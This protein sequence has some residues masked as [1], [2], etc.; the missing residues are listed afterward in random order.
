MCGIAGIYYFD[1][2]RVVRSDDLTAMTDRIVHRGPDDSGFHIDG[3]VGI[4]MRRLSIIDLAGGHQPMHTRDR[5]LSIVFNGEL[6]NFQDEKG[7]LERLGHQFSTRS[8]TEVVLQLFE[9]HGE[10]FTRHLNGMFGA[11]I[12]DAHSKELTLVRDHVGIKPLY[13]YR[14]RDVFLFASEIKA[15]LAFPGLRPEFDPG[16]LGAYLRHGFTPAP[17]TLFKGIRKLRPAETLRVGQNGVAEAVY[18]QPSYADKSRSSEDELKEELFSLIDD[19]V[20]RQ[21]IADVPI[22]AFLSG[23]FD[24]SGIVHLMSKAASAPISTYTVGFGEKY[25]THNE[26]SAAN[27]FSKDYGTHQHQIVVKP[28]VA[29]L[30]PGLVEALDEPIADSSFILT[31]LVAKL[32]RQSSTVIL[33]GVGGDELFGGYRRYLNVALSRPLKFVPAWVRKGMVMPLLRQLPADRNGRIPNLVRL[34]KSYLTSAD[35]PLEEQYGGY[36]QVLDRSLL[37]SLTTAQATTPDFYT[38][39]FQGCDSTELLDKMMYFDLK[40]SLPEQL[41]LLTDK[42]TMAVSLEARVP[43]LDYRIVEFAARLPARLKVNGFKLRYLQKE[44]FRGR[45]PDYVYAQPKKGFGAPVG[46][47]LRSEL[48]PLLND[49][50]NPSYLKAQG[51][52]APGPVGELIQRHKSR[53]EDHTDALWALIVFQIWGRAYGLA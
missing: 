30:L 21:M 51:I 14:D 35:L 3:N 1:R 47:W 27:R 25:E 28:D 6:F 4:A 11:A 32:A 43:L 31:Y 26:L 34:A 18:W 23:G 44:A 19:S 37:R 41:L 5:R 38:E 42:M 9:R 20:K 16:V 53:Q 49:F 2:N 10:A 48:E 39:H 12:W 13:Y 29:T 7:R 17:F 46:G 36:T 45:L 52:F 22:G 40:T 24:S 50:L 15:L 8:D 33:S